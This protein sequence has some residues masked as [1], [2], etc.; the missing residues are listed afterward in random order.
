[1][2]ILSGAVTA[3]SIAVTST[4]VIASQKGDDSA[5]L[6]QDA[7]LGVDQAMAI[8]LADVPGNVIEA[9]I[10]RENG[11]LIWEIE[12][13]DQQNQVYELEID[14]NSGEILEKELEDD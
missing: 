5:S 4:I 12:I 3:L 7:S 8:A 6:I 11:K 10:E 13:V 14:A 9:E 2:K 1:M